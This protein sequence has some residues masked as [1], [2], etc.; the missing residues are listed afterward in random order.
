MDF[1]KWIGFL[2]L[3]VSLYILWQ[4]RQVLLL[5]FLAVVLATAL[6]R[7]VQ[8][9]QRSKVKR[10]VAVLLSVVTLLTLL[11]GFVFVIVPPLIEQFQQLVQIVPA[12]L[13][14]LRGWADQLQSR[15]IPGRSLEDY[16]PNSNDLIRQIQPVAG[17][18]FGNFFNLFSNF[19]AI[20]V[21]LLL[22]LVLTIMLLGSPAPY[23]RG[24]I[25]LFPAFY[26]RRI[27][28][29]LTKCDVALGGWLAG[30]LF[31]MA[32]IT[33]LS[34]VGLLL[35]GVPLALVNALLAGLLTF[36]PNVGPTLSVIP[37]IAIALLD[38]PW[39]AIAVLLLYI[40]IQQIETNILTPRV[41]EKQVSLLPAV[42]LLSQVVF[43]VFFGF[44]GLLLALPLA[45]VAQVWLQEILVKD[46]LDNWRGNTDSTLPSPKHLP[47]QTTYPDRPEEG[48]GPS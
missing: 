48:L 18:L 2:A 12:G 27:D 46:V 45:V 24:F 31:N 30:I 34:G 40:G 47:E 23:R 32:V 25:Q 13:E 37:P 6:N 33:V 38:A 10:G 16:I 35:L 39:K 3:G 36:I 41:M 15:F 22:V 4:I 8:R 42:T 7:V 28:D 44:L 19:L 20:V 21:N 43:A 5:A 14:R 11:V 17:R 29:I 1:G 9:L 26:R